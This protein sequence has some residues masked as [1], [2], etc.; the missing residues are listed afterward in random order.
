MDNTV[1]PH[2]LTFGG[3]GHAGPGPQTIIKAQTLDSWIIGVTQG[4]FFMILCS[5]E[6]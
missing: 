1:D 5:P 4:A 6:G 3:G 2:A